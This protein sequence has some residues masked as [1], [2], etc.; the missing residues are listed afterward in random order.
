MMSQGLKSQAGN[1][2][3]R[4]ILSGIRI[5]E[6][7]MSRTVKLAGMLLADQGAEVVSVIESDS[8]N[9]DFAISL[10]LNRGK[11]RI[12]LNIS[13]HN[14][15]EKFIQL[16]QRTDILLED[17]GTHKLEEIG[18]NLLQIRSQWNPGLISCSLPGYPSSDPRSREKWTEAGVSISAGLYETTTGLGKP[19]FFSLPIASTYQALHAVNAVLMALIARKRD[20]CGQNIEIPMVKAALSTQ[21]LS[22]MIKSNPPTRWLPFQMLASPFMGMCKTADN[23]HVYVH[24]GIPRHLRSFLALINK[25]GFKEEKAGLKERISKKTRRDPVYVNGVREAIGVNRILKSLFMK[26]DALFWEDLLGDAGLCCSKVRTISEWLAHQQARESGDI[27]TINDGDNREINVP[28]T[29]MHIQNGSGSSLYV[30]CQEC[31]FSDLINKWQETEQFPDTNEQ[32]LPFEGVRVLDFSRVI[33]GPYAGKL[34][35]EYG[36]QVLQVTFRK[37]HLIWEEPFY[38]AFSGGKDSLAADLTT[39]EGRENFRKVVDDFKPDIVLHNFDEKAVKKLGIDYDSFKEINAN[40]IYIS[41]AAYNIKG[42]WKD[43][44]GFEWNIQASTG[45]LAAYS[46]IN[47]PKPL[48]IPVN[49]LC[50]GL[51]A[52]YGGALAYYH[53]LN[54]KGG[55]RVS[56]FLSAPSLLLQLERFNEKEGN[57]SVPISPHKDLNRFYRAKDSWFLLSV[58]HEHLKK[59]KEISHLHKLNESDCCNWNSHFVKTFR[60]RNFVWWKK[61]IQTAGC[62]K[63]IQ[64]VKRRKIKE[65]LKDELRSRIPLFEYK[66]H[67]GFGKVIVTNSAVYMDK[68]PVKRLHPAPYMGGDT[69]RFVKKSGMPWK[70]RCQKPQKEEAP[71]IIRPFIRLWWYLRQLKWI[72]V[73]IDK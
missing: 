8:K 59:L 66:H 61:E 12:Q 15:F 4:G 51:I 44:I 6:W 22:I 56:V 29:L 2:K 73:I 62:D 39:S 45:I 37:G 1:N 70:G 50:T 64:I 30:K 31:K 7:G 9:D 38:V 67:E 69:L 17:A 71:A 54:S 21:V 28:G 32:K 33:A 14:D 60:K 10:I 57:E 13:E 46:S 5:L 43:R 68:T 58:K 11:K 16:I 65:I 23:R 47:N 18:I 53:M 52:C 19:R 42:P 49:D 35:A 72:I 3:N 48:N 63:Y 25:A 34:F 41:V 27:I 24:I 40:V 36:A 26:K 20:G 55:N